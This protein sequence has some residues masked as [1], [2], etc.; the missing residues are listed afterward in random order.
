[1][2]TSLTTFALDQAIG[3]VVEARALVSPI[4]FSARYDL[5]RETGVIT[6]VDHPLRGMSVAGMVLICPAVQGGV[7]AGWT[8]MKLVGLGVGFAGMVFG[9]TNPVMVQGAQAAGLPIGAGIDPD[10]MHLIPANAIVRLD[11]LARRLTVI[12]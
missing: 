6:R 5:D 8:F 12:G 3:P 2:T 9:R 11:P 1:M 7:A 10:A 4:A